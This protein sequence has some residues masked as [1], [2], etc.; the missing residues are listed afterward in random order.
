MSRADDIAAGLARVR[1]RIAAAERAAGR[2]PGEVRLVA[3]SKKMTVDDVRGALAAGQLDLGESYGQELRDKRLAL[4]GALPAP[5]WHFIGPLQANKVKYVAGHVAL[6]HSV[7][8]A[9]LLEELERRAAGAA[10]AVL[11]QVNVAGEAQKRGVT[12]E[13]LP[14]LLD[15]FATLTRVRCEGL[16]TVP[17]LADDPAEARPHFAALRALREREAARA[18]PG[19]VLREL[20]MGMSHDL[21]VAVAEGATLVRVGTA[22]FGAR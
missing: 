7:D 14:A 17:P 3:V 9:E 12:P 11:V 6:V 1:A 20:S 16:M 10:Q 13:A 5:R 2:G 15:R 22:I 4:A 21:E 8:S 18:R 19:V